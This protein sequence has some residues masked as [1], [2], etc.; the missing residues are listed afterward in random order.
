MTACAN[1]C[2]DGQPGQRLADSALGGTEIRAIDHLVLPVTTLALARSRLTALGF[3]V[4]PDARHPFGT[5]NCCVFFKNS[6]Y[7]EP[8]TIMDRNAADLAAAERV[9]F[10]RRIKRFTE[11]RGEGFAM[12]ALT[13]EDAEADHI[14]FEK[15]G[16]ADGSTYHFV[17]D[18]TLPDGE[19]RE[20]GVA[21]AYAD[22]PAAPDAAFFACQHLAKEILFQ[23][24]YLEH[25]NG[26]LGVSTIVAVTE[27]PR[28]F[29]PFLATATGNEVSDSENGS[30]A[31][32]DGQNI[33]IV[34]PEEFQARYDVAPP[35]P[36]RGMLFSAFEL[37][38]LEIE[39]A[40]GYA[41]RGAKRHADR[42]VVPAAPGLGAVIAF[43][44]TPS[45]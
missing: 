22:F 32:L 42:I 15:A 6:T 3:T 5:G 37:E 21:L 45:G 12:V 18:A 16:I 34:T 7:L 17:R 20:I 24:E 11:R 40:A 28:D 43:R 27:R 10:V 23:P 39:R 26:V 29:A 19:E 14:V 4:A 2:T 35:N 38:V 36:R 8:I 1:A 31:D 25:P 41:G 9:V 30:Q 13:S 33:A 44:G